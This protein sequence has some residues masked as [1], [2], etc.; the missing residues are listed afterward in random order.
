MVFV[1]VDEVNAV[2]ELAERVD[3]ESC[4]YEGWTKFDLLHP[5]W[6]KGELPL[7]QVGLI[8]R[9]KPQFFTD[10]D[11]WKSFRDCLR[12]HHPFVNVP[13]GNKRALEGDSE[14]TKTIQEC[15]IS[16]RF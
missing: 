4:I 11:R 1:H 12:N 2:E 8:Q 16:K 10:I 13:Y 14:L 3:C 7:P 9:Q 5:K 6:F 15:W